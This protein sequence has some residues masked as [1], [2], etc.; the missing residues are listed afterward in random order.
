M[1]QPVRVI[2]VAYTCLWLGSC[3]PKRHETQTP[4]DTVSTSV[5][6]AETT[7]EPVGVSV[8]KRLQELG[9]TPDS[10][11][12]GLN[13][14]DAFSDVTKKEK[15]QPF[16]RDERH[17]GYTVEFKNLES[18][19]MLY[20]QQNNKL[21]AIQVDIFLNKAASVTDWRQDLRQYFSGQ[22]GVPVSPDVWRGKGVSVMLNDVSKGKDYGLK[23][24]IVPIEV[25]TTASAR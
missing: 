20:F 24:K 22:Y 18:A 3:Q 6:R 21:S 25:S 7:A 14:G 9:L 23:I 17:V 12:R 15:G 8:S 11:W 2:F 16:E 4:T 1:K 13:I 5:P 19:D 10:Q